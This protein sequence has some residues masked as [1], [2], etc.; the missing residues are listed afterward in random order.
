MPQ[1]LNIR[2]LPGFSERRPVIPPGGVYIGRT[3][4]RMGLSGSKWGNPFKPAKQGD[5]EAH[6][7]A[8]ALYRRWLGSQPMLL[9]ALPELRGDVL[10][11]L[12]N[13][14]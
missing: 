7:V 1:V 14:R 9:A 10:R 8:V 6:A 4:S 11:E 2:H 12:A 5:A 3:M 13:K